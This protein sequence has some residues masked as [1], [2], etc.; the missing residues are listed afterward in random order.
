MTRNER[1]R[2]LGDI[3]HD[4]LRA[5][6][7]ERTEDWASSCLRWRLRRPL[8]LFLDA[9]P[10]ACGPDWAA[11]GNTLLRGSELAGLH[12]SEKRGAP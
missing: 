10:V 11:Y 8:V 5:N 12:T 3:E 7:A 1:F 4:P 9:G 6:M 2:T